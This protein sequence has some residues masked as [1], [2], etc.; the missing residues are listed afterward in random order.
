M[1]PLSLF[2]PK[3]CCGCH[4]IGSFLCS[5]CQEK[6]Y[7]LS[8]PI[9]LKLET[10]YVD[11]NYS[12]AS[13]DE[14]IKSLLHELKYNHVKEIGKLCGQLLYFGTNWPTVDL[15]TCT[16]LHSKRQQER[17]YNQSEIIAKAF[18][19]L[20]GIPFAPLLL[21]TKYTASQATLSDKSQRLTNLEKAIILNP[22]YLA[23]TKQIRVIL[24]DDVVTTG[25]TLNT[26]AQILKSNNYSQVFG[27]TM[28]HGA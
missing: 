2:F 5:K 23:P 20:S 27:L 9:T 25:T 13:Y 28:A 4:K 3:F 17:G 19:K 8:F 24:I 11:A 22:K 15:V 18:S 16:P 1:D 10:I 26:C 12:L 14:P 7:Y 6:V 21:K